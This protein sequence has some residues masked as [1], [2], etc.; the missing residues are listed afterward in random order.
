MAERPPKAGSLKEALFLTV[1]H[2][3][4]EAQVL[5]HRM[6][7]QGLSDLTAA[8]KVQSSVGD[9]F[10]K[11]V[12]AKFPWMKSAEAAKDSEMKDMMQKQVAKG[13]LTFKPMSMDFLKKKAEV[14]QMPD[15]WAE[16]LRERVKRDKR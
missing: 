16:K 10:K 13:V 2:R 3:R 11:Y 1:W 14:M 9:I 15:E 6:L 4:Q 5:E 8:G 12:E 7:A